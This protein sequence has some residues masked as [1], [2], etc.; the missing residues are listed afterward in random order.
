MGECKKF[1]GRPGRIVA[2]A[3]VTSGLTRVQEGT[4]S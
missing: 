3:G 2:L 1:W 4:N